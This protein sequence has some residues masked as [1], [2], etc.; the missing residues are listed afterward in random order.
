VVLDG[1]RADEELRRYRLVRRALADEPGDLQLLRR[2]LGQRAEV[3]LAG[4]LAGRA[5][6]AARTVGPRRCAETVEA[7]DG[8]AQVPAGVDAPLGAAQVLAVVQLDAGAIER[9]RSLEPRDR[10]L[11]VRLGFLGRRRGER[12][13]V[14]QHRRRPRGRRADDPVAEQG[15]SRFDDVGAMDAHRRLDTIPRAQDRSHRMTE[16]RAHLER[17]DQA[18]KRLLPAARADVQL[19]QR[20]RSQ[21]GGYRQAALG[22]DPVDVLGQTLALLRV[23]A[24]PGDPSQA[25]HRQ[26]AGVLGADVVG[27]AHR[28]GGEL[29]RLGQESLP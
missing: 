15:D 7:V 19:G 12:P 14:G 27:E 17:R 1:L 10:G 16:A 2:E 20:P 28:F 18:D 23:A 4:G 6:L 13:A 21:H 25:R 11:E 9:P 8:V 22:G 29:R 3:A 5:Q 24:Q 26:G